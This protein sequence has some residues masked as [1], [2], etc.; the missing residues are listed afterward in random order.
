[1]VS[2]KSKAFYCLSAK[3]ENL[4]NNIIYFTV[5]FIEEEHFCN[6]DIDV[7]FKKNPECGFQNS[8]GT[9]QTYLK[10]LPCLD[11]TQECKRFV[12]I[13]H[14]APGLPSAAFF[15][16]CCKMVH[17]CSGQERQPSRQQTQQ[18]Q[19][20]RDV[21][22]LCVSHPSPLIRHACTGS[23]SQTSLLQPPAPRVERSEGLFGNS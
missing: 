6:A 12:R 19:I 9:T 7:A 2:C 16:C 1:M 3:A 10:Q 15:C 13:T 21:I 14:T 23:C 17:W 18:N 20:R 4:S 8:R 11:F 5:K 22:R